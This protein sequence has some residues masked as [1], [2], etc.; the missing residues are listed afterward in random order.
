MEVYPYECLVKELKEVEL[1]KYKT[2]IYTPLVVFNDAVNQ[3]MFHHSGI[4]KR[5]KYLFEN[6]KE[7]KKWEILNGLLEKVE[8]QVFPL[9]LNYF[10]NF[11]FSY[12]RRW[13]EII[14]YFQAFFYLRKG[15]KIY[16]VE[17]KILSK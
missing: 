5:N 15:Y 4:S 9:R 2:K 17:E 7:L 10:I 12:F 14:V 8:L 16:D 13:R 11:I 6:E 3:N 1:N